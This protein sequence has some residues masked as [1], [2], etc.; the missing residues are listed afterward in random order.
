VRDGRGEIGEEEVRIPVSEEEL[1]VEKRPRVKEELVVRKRPVEETQEIEADLRRE[2]ID[3]ETRGR[4]R[5][6]RGGEGEQGLEG[7]SEEQRRR[8]GGEGQRN[9]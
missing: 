3:I 7:E 8:R 4:V 9:R 5:E 6:M 2:E 1:V